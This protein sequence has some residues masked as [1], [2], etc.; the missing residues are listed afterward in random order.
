MTLIDQQI[1]QTV[2]DFWFGAEG[3]DSW[4]SDRKEWWL[5]DDV[6]D[7]AVR[8]ILGPLQERAAN[9]E[10]DDWTGDP[11]GCVALV[12]LLD[13]APRNLF[14]GEAKAFATDERARGVTREALAHGLDMEVPEFMRVFLYMPLEH[15]ENLDDQELCV[16]LMRALGN[17]RYVDF[18][19]RHR[20]II[21]RFGRFPHRNDVLGRASTPEEI[22]F[23]KQPNSSF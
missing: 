18:A 5:K 6:F 17:D 21:A 19:I 11:Y 14:R 8:G 2:I 15:S 9:G 20:D 7:A 1:I 13:Q 10:I 3:S 22:E 12:I 4:G 16:D 23:L